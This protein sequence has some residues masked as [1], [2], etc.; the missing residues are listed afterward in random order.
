MKQRN[1]FT[2]IELLVV[3]AII[4]ILAAMLLPAL[5]KAREKARSIAC[6]NQ[7]KT[8]VMAQILYV[9]DNDGMF[10]D[11]NSYSIGNGYYKHW[12][13]LVGPY[14]GVDFTQAGNAKSSCLYC[15]CDQKGIGRISASA[16]TVSYGMNSYHLNFVYSTVTWKSNAG[17]GAGAKMS[18]IK[19]PSQILCQGEVGNISDDMMRNDAL[20]RYVE[21]ST[22]P[23]ECP[24]I[25][26]NNGGNHSFVDGHVEF[27]SKNELCYRKTTAWSLSSANKYFGF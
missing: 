24:T 14:L 8:W 5:S 16:A 13:Y 7:Q 6:T 23:G 19:N 1:P 17:Y 9:D 15:P 2:L 26:H 18:S 25:R 12:F 20:V 4:A 22:T 10:T 3:I 21:S 11:R 27:M